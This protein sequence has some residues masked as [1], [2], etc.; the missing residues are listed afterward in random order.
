LVI[1]AM[2]GLITRCH[3]E[4][5]NRGRPDKYEGHPATIYMREDIIVHAVNDFFAERVFGA[6]RRDL[7]LA[8]VDAADDEGQ[9]QRDEQRARLQRK[10]ADTTRKQ[11]N[12]LRQAEDADPND[13]FTQGL[14][15]RYNELDAERQAVLASIAELDLQNSQEP[16]RPSIEA[17]DLFDALPHLAVNLHKAPVELLNKLFD[18]TQLTIQVHYRTGEATLKVTLPDDHIAGVTETAYELED[19]VPEGCTKTAGQSLCASCTC[20]RCDSNAH[21]TDFESASY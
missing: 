6:A 3:P 2:A 5:N 17:I 18:L 8:N 9:R 4:N 20:P 16:E 12:V 11:D 15:S 10:L 7:F 19:E 13:P 14:R 1:P 21:W